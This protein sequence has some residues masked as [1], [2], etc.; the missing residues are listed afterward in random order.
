VLHVGEEF[1]LAVGIDNSAALQLDRGTFHG[2]ATL[3]DDAAGDNELAAS[4][5][6]LT[7]H[8]CSGERPL[9]VAGSVSGVLDVHHGIDV[10]LKV[11]RRIVDAQGHLH[12]SGLLKTFA[13]DRKEK[14]GVIEANTDFVAVIAAAEGVGSLALHL[15]YDPRDGPLAEVFL[16]RVDEQHAVIGFVEIGPHGDGPDPQTRASRRAVS[17]QQLV[18]T[19]EQGCLQRDTAKP[20]EAAEAIC[21]QMVD[22][23][24]NRCGSPRSA[25]S[26]TAG[27]PLHR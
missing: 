13:A 17:L 1:S 7:I 10:G 24:K 21:G 8:G 27:S 15:V 20:S 22:Q 19:I 3:I 11:E 5:L 25:C 14:N 6:A 26:E 23:K 9:H 12:A 4:A 16:D 18:L 2:L